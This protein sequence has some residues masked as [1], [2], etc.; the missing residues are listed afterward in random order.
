MNI[1]KTTQSSNAANNMMTAKNSIGS[2]LSLMPG[3]QPINRQT[4][5]PG[6][7][8]M[9]KIPTLQQMEFSKPESYI[10]EIIDFLN[11]VTI[12]N[13]VFA[14]K[15]PKTLSGSDATSL[16]FKLLRLFAPNYS[17]PPKF[18]TDEIQSLFIGLC[19]PCGQIRSDSITAVGAPST[20]SYLMRAIYWLYQV[21]RVYFMEK[22]QRRS[23]AV[24]K[25]EEEDDEMIN[26]EYS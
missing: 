17:A 23:S 6:A 8:G 20:V 11:Q 13:D 16:I 7:Y 15:I 5:G 24:I 9:H 12:A 18:T 14:Q 4:V 3:S 19:Y 2:K 26:D 10:R 21:S 25:E 22:K 1:I